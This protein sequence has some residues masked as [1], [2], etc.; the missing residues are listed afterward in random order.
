[1][2]K[3]IFKNSPLIRI[4]KYYL[5]MTDAEIDLLSD[6][7]KELINYYKEHICNK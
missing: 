4:V 5:S 1:M 6:N 3:E 2:I 7:E